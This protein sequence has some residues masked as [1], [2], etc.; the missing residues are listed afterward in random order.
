M[1][2]PSLIQYVL[3][4]I[5]DVWPNNSNLVLCTREEDEVSPITGKQLS[6]Q[7]GISAAE[8]RY[9]KDGIW[10]KNPATFPCAFH[11]E[12]GYLIVKDET[13]WARLKTEPVGER[14]YTVQKQTTHFRDPGISAVPGYQRRISNVLPEPEPTTLYGINDIISDGCFLDRATLDSMLERLQSRRNLILQGPPGTGKTWLAKKLAYALIGQ[15]DEDKVRQVQ[16]HPNLSYEDFVRGWRPQGDG[17]LGLVDGPFLELSEVARRDLNGTYVIVIEEINRGSPASIFGELLTLLEADKRTRDNGLTLAHKRTAHE[18]F[19]IPPNLYVI[20]TMNLADRSLAL[21]DLALRR[22]FAFFDL[23]PVLD[24]TWRSWVHQ[25]CKIPTDFLVGI[26]HRIT[27]LNE[28]I[29]ADPNLGRQFRIGHSFVVPKSGEPIAIPED[30]F[31]QVVET[32]IAPLLS[33]YWFDDPDKV[34][35]AKAQLLNDL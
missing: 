6:K 20:G 33:E 19:Y 10:Y 3:Q 13:H 17:A 12:N 4:P 30:W 27:S 21:V 22:R 29:A 8:S 16:F 26:S 11:D 9:R 24:E 34:D 7:F 32:E 31:G 2:I 28:Q 25:Q 15:K 35:E 5:Y 14:P 1:G 18:S 23:E